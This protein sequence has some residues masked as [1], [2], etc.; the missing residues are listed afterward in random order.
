[1]TAGPITGTV[2]DHVAHAVPRWQDVW[3]RYATEFGAE[4]SSGGP[5]PGFAPAQLRF[6]NGARVEVL[7]PNDVDANDFLARFLAHNGPGP[8]HVTF[9]VPDLERAI[10]L[11][12]EHGVDP[13]GIDVSDPEWL[14]AFIHPKQA[15]GVVVQ[16]A[17]QS[18]AWSSPAP[19]DYPTARR[20]RRDGSGTVPPASLLR[21][22]HAVADLDAALALFCSLLGGVVGASGSSRG[23]RWAELDW[24]GPL[25][26]RLVADADAGRGTQHGPLSSWLGGRTGRVHHLELTS[27]EPDT[28]RH[29]H[30]HASDV[31][32]TRP[33][34]EG[35]EDVW[36]IDPADN[37]GLRLVVHPPR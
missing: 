11:V 3:G 35:S 10:G 18:V 36:E 19:G 12:R 23:V 4:W 7:M 31:V 1:M 34:A 28:I 33:W 21:V 20:Q 25:G 2:L 22:T 16:L 29:A 14:E 27:Q 8:H 32:V 37:F 6:A 13:I 5:G 26:I 24:P 30:R 9:K 17:Q 15:S